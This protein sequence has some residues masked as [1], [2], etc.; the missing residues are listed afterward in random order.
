MTNA[1]VT[2]GLTKD[3]GNGHGIFDLDVAVTEG[4]V[5]GYLGP[6]GAGKTTTLKILM[7]L[8]HASRGGATIFGL[9]VDRDAVAL[10]KRIG[11]VPGELPQ[12]GGW[13][14]AE[15]VGYVAGLR[16]DVPADTVELIAKRLD[17]DLGR[18]YREYSH[19]NKQKLAL[20]LAFAPEPALLI[21]DE[22]TTGL[23]PLH[24]QVF[25]ALVQEAKAR[26]AT[27]L[28]SSH[29]LSEV[30]Q[31]CDRVGIVRE[32]HLATVGPIDQLTG[33]KAH[34]V[35]IDFAGAPPIDRLR[36]LP[37]FEQVTLEGSRVRGLYRGSFDP[38]LAAISGSPVTSLTSR[39]PSLEEIFLSYYSVGDPPSVERSSTHGRYSA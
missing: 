8:I 29:V 6:N 13:R 2:H 37:G 31:V 1:I 7:G 25:Q 18:K 35:A 3:Y 11:Y 4:E 17:L 30:E 19:G 23:D 24:Q 33:I 5:F 16:G 9:D 26:G 36:A 20:L 12:F 15:I 27:V 14:G 21:V 39:E 10:K 22:P 32:G 38:L 34:H 28:I